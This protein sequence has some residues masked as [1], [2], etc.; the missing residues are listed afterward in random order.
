MKDVMFDLE[1]LGLTPGSAIRSIGARAFNPLTGEL[2]SSFY[3]NV[4]LESCVERELSIDAKTLLWWQKQELAAQEAL[5]PNQLPLIVVAGGFEYWWHS[6]GYSTVWA[7]GAAFDIPL[8]EAATGRTGPW[9]YYRVMDTRTIHSALYYTGRDQAERETGGTLHNA[10][11]DCDR[12]I[13]H[14][15]NAF[16]LLAVPHLEESG[17]GAL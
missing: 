6:G 15:H 4:T 3:A 9:A 14:L 5:R 11:D 7:N 8:W 16:K 13:A 12:Q 17:D 2:G 1:T 10:L